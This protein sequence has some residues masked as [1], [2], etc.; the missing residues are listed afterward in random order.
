MKSVTKFMIA[1]VVVASCN[2]GVCT[3]DETQAADTTATQARMTATVSE[4]E[5]HYLYPLKIRKKLQVTMR[6]IWTWC[7]QA[8][9]VIRRSAPFLL[10]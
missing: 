5:G 7:L 10:I 3:Y 1:A 8:P 6:I 9:I 2:G 4:T